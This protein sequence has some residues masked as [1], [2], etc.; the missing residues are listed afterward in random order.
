MSFLSDFVKYIAAN[1]SLIL[2]TDLFVGVDVVDAPLK[3]V[4]VQESGGG[5]ENESGMMLQP[6][7][8]IVKAQSYPEAREL[9]YTV[10]DLLNNKSGFSSLSGVFYCEVFSL[11]AL[12]DRG[13]LGVYIFSTN[14]LL[15]RISSS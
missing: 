3:C 8:V 4:I 1:S 7:Q 6:I 12:I 14:F 11:P 5:T 13:E 10:Y 9:S 2:D 15:K